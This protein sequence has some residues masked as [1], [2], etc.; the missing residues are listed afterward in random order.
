MA[1]ITPTIPVAPVTPVEPGAQ[2]DPATTEPVTPVDPNVTPATTEQVTPV[3]TPTPSPEYVLLK[4]QYEQLKN[5]QSGE[6]RKNTELQNQLN[7][8]RAQFDEIKLSKMTEK[9]K[10][11][12][13]I[14]KL[15]DEIRLRDEQIIKAEFLVKVKEAAENVIIKH[16]LKPEDMDFIYDENIEVMEKKGEMLKIRDKK[17]ID[18][19]MEKLRGAQSTGRPGQGIA[20]PIVDNKTFTDTAGATEIYKKIKLEQGEEAAKKWWD[21]NKKF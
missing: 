2:A 5:S 18:E 7:E 1:E 3:V 10:T 16:E 14:N 15:R 8:M 19:A 13:E 4:T 12:F 20:S 21:E 11:E 6:T 9:E 17:I